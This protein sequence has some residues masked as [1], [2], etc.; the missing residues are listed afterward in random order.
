MTHYLAMV[1]ADSEDEVQEVLA[2]YDENI[3]VEPYFR[4]VDIKYMVESYNTTDIFQLKDM[5]QN[6]VGE[7]EVIQD[8]VLGYMSTYNPLSKWDWNVIGGRWEDIV[9]QNIA[10]LNDIPGIFEG[11]CVSEGYDVYFPST[12]VTKDGWFSSKDWGWF[13]CY[14]E[15]DK[16]E[17]DEQFKLNSDKNCFIVDL[18]I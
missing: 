11:Y 1:V 12:L 15:L 7:E 9:N 10:K 2:K 6:W 17:F 13:G 5:M 4:P 8:G 3:D 18:H 16:E 14:T